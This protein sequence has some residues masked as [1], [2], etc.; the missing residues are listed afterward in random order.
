[1]NHRCFT[2]LT[3]LA[4]L[5]AAICTMLPTLHGPTDLATAFSVSLMLALSVTAFIRWLVLGDQKRRRRDARSNHN[6]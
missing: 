6:L 1:M 3:T 4:T 2:L 5:T